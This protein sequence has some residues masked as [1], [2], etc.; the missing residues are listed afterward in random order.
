VKGDWKHSNSADPLRIQAYLYRTLQTGARKVRK[1]RQRSPCCCLFSI[2]GV[3]MECFDRILETNSLS[4]LNIKLPLEVKNSLLTLDKS[5]G[6]VIYLL[7]KLV[8]HPFP[9]LTSENQYNRIYS[10]KIICKR[11]K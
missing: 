11:K 1:L 2:A 8:K 9:E 4:S 6:N 7:C 3:Q 5:S 10:Y